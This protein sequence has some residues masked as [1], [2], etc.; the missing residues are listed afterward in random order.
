MSW[1]EVERK[2]ELDD[3][4]VLRSRLAARDWRPGDTSTE[5]DTYYSRMVKLC[6]VEKTRTPFAHPDRTEVTVVID[7]VA[8]IGWFVETEVLAEKTAEAQLLLEHIEQQL[9]LSDCSIVRLPCRDL[10]LQR[11]QA[12]TDGPAPASL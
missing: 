5:V 2:R 9:S 11:G 1:I 6:Q 4:A 10:L 3:P 8:G 12:T 7:H